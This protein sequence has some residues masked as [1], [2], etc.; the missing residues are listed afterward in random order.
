MNGYIV[1]LVD[2][3]EL[4]V[5]SIIHQWQSFI[6]NVVNYSRYSL[7]APHFTHHA[8]T[9][10]VITRCNRIWRGGAPYM[11]AMQNGYISSTDHIKL[12]KLYYKVQIGM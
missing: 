11:I 10:H 6:L 8:T 5:I 9:P 3:N 4:S 1:Q 7:N 12:Y 2:G